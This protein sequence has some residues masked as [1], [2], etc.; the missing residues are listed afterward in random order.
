MALPS[1]TFTVEDG[2]L[3]VISADAEDVA[4]K[5]GICSAGVVDQVYQVSTLTALVSELG[6]GPLVDA[7]ALSL[8]TAGGPIWCV[9]LNPS[10]AGTIAGSVSAVAHTGT[11]TSVMT[12]VGSPLKDFSLVITVSTAVGLVSAGTGAITYSLDGG[13]TTSAPVVVPASGILVLPNTGLTLYFTTGGS[14][15]LADTY[16]ATVNDTAEH[17]AG[18]GTSVLTITG[19][20]TDEFS[21]LIQGVGPNPPANVSLGTSA[22]TYSLDGGNLTSAPVTIP[23][24]GI[25]AI[26]G[27][28]LT[29]NFTTGATLGAGDIYIALAIAPGYT[30]TDI[31]NGI[32]AAVAINEDFGFFHLVGQAATTAASVALFA[33]LD[34][35]MNSLFTEQVFTFLAMEA[36]KDTDSAIIAA[37]GPT[38]ASSRR[39]MVCAGTAF[40]SSPATNL[41]E[42]QSSGWE[43]AARIAKIPE[44]EDIGNVTTGPVQGIPT[45]VASGAPGLVRDERMTPGF[46]AIGLA[47]LST[48]EGA[49]GVFANNSANMKSPVGSDFFLVQYRRVMDR[50]CKIAKAAILPYLNGSLLLNADGTIAESEARHIESEVNQKLIQALVTAP[51]GQSHG[52][53]SAV[54]VH[55]SRTQN[56]ESTDEMPTEVNVQPLGYSKFIPTT[57]TFVNGQA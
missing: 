20:P 34:S 32:N 24:S 1:V 42:E 36:P 16:D 48:I 31:T 53:A 30:I 22:I 44:S 7:A 6:T 55:I 52:Q 17:T 3:G 27:T 38:V 25:F 57:I 47:T 5:L 26:P 11:G 19:A 2:G 35:L 9:P 51:P 50:A 8:A 12:I 14:F 29:L 49:T 15:V 56:I 45:T 28:G 13:A 37:W 41:I 18:T 4:V 40:V 46:D 10:V 43:I 33:S 21:I 39:M 54:G 23:A